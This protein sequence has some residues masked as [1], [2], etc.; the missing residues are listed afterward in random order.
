MTQQWSIDLDLEPEDE[1]PANQLP[2]GEKLRMLADLY[3]YAMSN[4]GLVLEADPSGTTEIQD[5]LRRM[6]ERLDELDRS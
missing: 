2:D 3:D 6:A 1:V 5:D 4:G